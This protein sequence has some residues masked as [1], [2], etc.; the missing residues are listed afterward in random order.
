APATLRE[1]FDTVLGV[2]RR[3][4]IDVERDEAA[5]GLAELA[6]IIVPFVEPARQHQVWH[7]TSLRACFD[8]DPPL[9]L[10]LDLYEALGVRDDARTAELATKIL[11]ESM[12]GGDPVFAAYALEAA[13]HAALFGND[14]AA[15]AKLLQVYAPRVRIDQTNSLRLAYLQV[16][17]AARASAPEPGRVPSAN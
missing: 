13:M 5:K 4:K 6:E 9:A 14:P 11:R 10:R 12:D 17:A 15:A 8:R 2:A 16:L 1:A 3:C 7:A